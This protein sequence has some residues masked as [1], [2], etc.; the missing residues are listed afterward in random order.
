VRASFRPA[1]I[2]WEQFALAAPDVDVLL[3]P[4]FTAPVFCRRPMV[5]VF[6]DLQHKRHPEFFRWFDLPAWQ[7]L[8]YAA[9]HRSA[10]LIAVSEATRADLLR[11]YRIPDEK[12]RVVP[13]GVDRAFF[14]LD[15]THTDPYL[16]AVST[17]HPHK[18]LERLLRVFA[19]FRRRQPEFRLV[20]AG[21]RGFESNVLEKTR[22]S[23]GLEDAVEMTGWIQRERL[24]ELFAKA[25]AFVYPSMFEGFGMPVLEALAA[26][27]PAAC[28]R[29]EPLASLASDAAVLF[30]PKDDA[31]MLD[32]LTRIV[33]EE[34]LRQELSRRGPERAKEF[35]WEKSARATLKAIED[36]AA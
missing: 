9:A 15:R 33:C 30:D 21:V 34:G 4:G 12:I 22:R 13:H 16:L 17:L 3:N 25:R 11:Y 6:H 14:A 19:D 28:S 1:R 20:I 7:I 35:S 36:T 8:L 32:A 10:R 2:V 23:L 18:N 5:T 29:I 31:E 27:I 24:Y 26:G